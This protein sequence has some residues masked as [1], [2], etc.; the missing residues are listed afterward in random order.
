MNLFK[1]ICAS[2]L[3]ILLAFQIA[4][5]DHRKLRYIGT[6]DGTGTTFSV[7]EEHGDLAMF[8]SCAGRYGSL[9][10]VGEVPLNISLANDTTAW[11]IVETGLNVVGA[12]CPKFSVRDHDNLYIQLYKGRYAE[13]GPDSRPAVSLMQESVVKDYNIHG[14][15]H[16]DNRKIENIYENVEAKR[17]KEEAA[18]LA[19]RAQEAQQRELSAKTFRSITPL[20]ALFGIFLLIVVLLSKFPARDK[21]T[22]QYRENGSYG[23]AGSDTNST[24]EQKADWAWRD[25]KV[26]I[27]EKN[28]YE[29]GWLGNTKVGEVKDNIFSTGKTIY[30]EGFFSSDKVGKVETN[31]WG[32]PTSILDNSGNKVGNIKTTW[33]GRQIIVDEDGNELG[34]YKDE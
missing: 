12:A 33:T 23:D 9:T 28:V 21:N 7:L 2:S 29:E 25:D 27:D 10:I 3:A 34:E 6:D 24:T 11:S 14:W 15:I 8:D 30:K 17:V 18:L 5:A 16:P 22:T 31:F 13:F 4:Q 20:V 32:T 26:I 1:I 19:M